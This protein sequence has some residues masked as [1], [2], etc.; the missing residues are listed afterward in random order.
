MN[1]WRAGC[2]ANS[3][4]RFGE[5]AGETVQV[6]AWNRA[7]V[8]FHWATDALDTVRRQVWNDERGGNGRATAGRSP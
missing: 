1:S 3:H 2:G 4:V 6:Q 5:R 7:P 8:R